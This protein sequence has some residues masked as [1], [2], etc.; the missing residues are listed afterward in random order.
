VARKRGCL[1]QAFSKWKR[2]GL[3]ISVASVTSKG[4]WSDVERMR[5]VSVLDGNRELKAPSEC[6]F[7]PI[8]A[9]GELAIEEGEF[10]ES[11]GV[12][13]GVERVGQRLVEQGVIFVRGDPQEVEVAKEDPGASHVG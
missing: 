1:S 12:D 6:G 10:K 5:E 4:T 7:L 2:F 11:E 9:L 13:A 8:I 3:G